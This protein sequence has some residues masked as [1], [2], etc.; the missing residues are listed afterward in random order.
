MT[1][2]GTRIYPDVLPPQ[3]T[4]PA[5]SYSRISTA[6]VRSL[7]GNSHLAMPRFQFT[8]WATTYA[9][10]R[11]L[12]DEIIVDL[13]DYS[14]VVGGITIQATRIDNELDNYDPTS[15]IYSVIADFIIAH[16]E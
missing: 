10:A 3:V 9:L 11:Q 1:I 5:I 14:G 12:M 13:N 8:A 16:T 15:G 4:L 2:A 6:R 7:S